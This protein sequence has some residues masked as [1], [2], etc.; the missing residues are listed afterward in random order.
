MH[1]FHRAL[2]YQPRLHE[3]YIM[4]QQ[5]DL[6]HTGVFAGGV[7]EADVPADADDVANIPDVRVASS[8]PRV[9]NALFT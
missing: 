7:R 4:D 8:G 9:H 5:G 6:V 2:F 3:T 1:G